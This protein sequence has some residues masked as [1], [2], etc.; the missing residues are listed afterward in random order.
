[1]WIRFV[2]SLFPNVVN[3]MAAFLITQPP[4]NPTSD[5]RFEIKSFACI[6]RYINNLRSS[7]GVIDSRISDITKWVLWIT[8]HSLR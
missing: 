3:D 2:R 8:K 7:I 5:V 1:M 4:G 6:I